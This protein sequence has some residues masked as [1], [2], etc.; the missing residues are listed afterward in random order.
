MEK[1]FDDMI[2]GQQL[3]DLLR[4]AFL[5]GSGSPK[6][7]QNLYDMTT[8]IVFSE[9]FAV[10]IPRPKEKAFLKR[11]GV[12]GAAFR[13]WWLI[14]L[15]P[16]LAAGL[17]FI[18]GR[19]EKNIMPPHAAAN[20]G[21]SAVA[22]DGA[23]YRTGGE[24]D[25]LARAAAG[26]D[27]PDEA[28]VFAA[29]TSGHDSIA[30]V[31]LVNN[32]SARPG[33]QAPLRMPED[34]Y[35]P[36]DTIPVLTEAMKKKY[37]RQKKIMMEQ[38]QNG[39]PAHNRRAKNESYVYVPSG[40]FHFGDSIVSVQAFYMSQ[41]EVSNLQ[42]RT[43]LYDLVAQG[44]TE[45]YLAARVRSENWSRALSEPAYF[46]KNYF[47]N[48]KYDRY[49]VV[50]ITREGAEMYCRW[51]TDEINKARTAAGENPMWMCAF[52]R[53]SGGNMPLKPG[54]IPLCFPGTAI[55]RSGILPAALCA[56]SCCAPVITS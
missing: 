15:V 31:R 45:E 2:D 25:H 8:A 41:T 37:A 33:Y 27:Y 32:E 49:P 39:S 48:E 5:S 30:P 12:P 50:N 16:V 20:P 26:A 9:D 13:F 28:G 54:V 24:D 6:Q 42:Y 29:D 19:E 36:N 51:L 21:D 7:T 22:P 4:E 35:G 46:E 47:S 38:V 23:Q 56:T 34:F 44:R 18:P 10:S 40:S 52:R 1:Q 55:L 43:F 3:D 11:L 14:L 53:S 17:F